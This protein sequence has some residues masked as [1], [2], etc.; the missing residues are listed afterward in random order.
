MKYAIAIIGGYLLG[1]L[2][3]TNSDVPW[4]LVI[5]FGGCWGVLVGVVFQE[6]A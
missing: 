2:L 6:R 3:A 5:A 4:W 1:Y